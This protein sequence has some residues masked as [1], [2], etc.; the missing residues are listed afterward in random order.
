MPKVYHSS[1]VANE[2]SPGMG[3]FPREALG[4]RRRES[5]R[6]FQQKNDAYSRREYPHSRSKRGL[7]DDS[8][9]F[10]YLS[11][12]PHRGLFIA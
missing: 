7:V 2:R 9:A 5:E 1:I 3:V 12:I 10:L 4:A 8:R 11:S 6:I